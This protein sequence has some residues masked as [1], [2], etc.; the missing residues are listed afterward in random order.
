[1]RLLALTCSLHALSCQ[2]LSRNCRK[3]LAIIFPDL[4]VLAAPVT[5]PQA[6][7]ANDFQ[8][9]LGAGKAPAGLLKAGLHARSAQFSLWGGGL[10]VTPR[11]LALLGRKVRS[12]EV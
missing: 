7:L 5:S 10:A 6:V 3:H 1:M 11:C 12:E 9:R 2:A 4:V 8:N